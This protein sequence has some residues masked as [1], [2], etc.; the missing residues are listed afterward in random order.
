MCENSTYTW[1]EVLRD[2]C[3]DYDIENKLCEHHKKHFMHQLEN[4]LVS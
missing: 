4:A 1:F 3:P 2:T